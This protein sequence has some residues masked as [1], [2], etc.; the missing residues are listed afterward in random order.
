MTSPCLR[1]GACCAHF[2]VSFYWAEAESFL[3]G[4]VPAELTIPINPHRVAMRG[5]QHSPPRCT[6]LSGELGTQVSCSIYAQRPTPC[7]EFA[8][9]WADGQHNERCDRAR[10][11]FGLPPL[12]PPTAFEPDDPGSTPWPRSA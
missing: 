10:A 2:R 7:R 9:S 8:Q 5:T 1:C 6:A 4:T 12:Q 11:A 3:G